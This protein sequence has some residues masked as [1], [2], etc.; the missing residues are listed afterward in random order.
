M[1]ADGTVSGERLAVSGGGGGRFPL[2]AYCSLLTVLLSCRAT[3]SRP[4][5]L[6]L[7]AAAIGE[8]E[9]EIPDATRALAEALAVDSI[10]LR[11]IKERDGFIDSGWLDSRTLE[12]TSAR[13]L[14]TDVVRV[15][16]WVNPAKQ[17]WSELVIEA[18]YR[19]M[20]DPS[21]PERELDTALP[22]DHPLQRRVGGVLRKLIERYGD[23]EALKS[24]VAPN[25]AATAGKKDSTVVKPDS[26]KPKPKPDSI[27][28][29]PKPDTIPT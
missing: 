7:P 29:R 10:A 17:F 19:P 26:T 28:T 20:A 9:M 23:R 12:Q 8:I 1:S 24:L 6:P 27:P 4:S 3:T 13:P 15:R 22:D 2:T 11:T 21:R 25:A 16:A 5:Y 14:G 18:T